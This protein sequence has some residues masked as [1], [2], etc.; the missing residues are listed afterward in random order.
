MSNSEMCKLKQKINKIKTFESNS[1]IYNGD[2]TL[3]KEKNI[4]ESQNNKT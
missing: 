1:Q 4:N 2:K 3:T